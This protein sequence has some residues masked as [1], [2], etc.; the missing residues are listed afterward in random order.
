MHYIQHFLFRLKCAWIA[1]TSSN[2]MILY[3]IS[4]KPVTFEQSEFCFEMI[5][6]T[7][8]TDKEDAAVLRKMAN[9]VDRTAALEPN[10]TE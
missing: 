7:S 1:L 2:I 9:D 10:K 5:R 6:D 4:K 8:F 3:P